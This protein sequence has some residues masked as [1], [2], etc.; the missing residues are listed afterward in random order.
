[1]GSFL[2]IDPK[3]MKELLKLQFLSQSPLLSA[4]S[5]AS[6]EMGTDFSSLLQ[7]L[8]SQT[9]GQ[10][11]N[12]VLGADSSLTVGNPSPLSKLSASYSP[13]HQTAV[14][15]NYDSLIEN[16]ASTYGLDASLI[17][18]VIHQES[19]FDTNSVSGAG[20]KGLMQLMDDTGR[21][22]GVT[23]PYDPQ[24]NIEGGSRFLSEL[25]HKYSGNVGT[26]LAAYNAGPGRVDRLG[27]RNDQ[28]LADKLTQLPKE[29]Q[30]YVKKV[31]QLQNSYY[32]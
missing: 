8:T 2:N 9:D 32:Q 5:T 26:A 22:L 29:T 4:S 12:E 11:G 6:E 1:M 31:L 16:A 24:Q 7:L 25:L 18:A 27:I 14:T 10:S 21:G 28:D 13:I 17:K 23:N 19:G 20:A 15:S 30:L 3:V